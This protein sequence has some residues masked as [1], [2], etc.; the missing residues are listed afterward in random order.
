M[1][2]LYFLILLSL[3]ACGVKQTSLD[4]GKTTVADLVAIKGE[5]EAEEKIPVKEGK[6]LIYPDDEKYQVKGEVVTGGFK[7]PK[8]NEKTLIYW[9]HKLKDCE[10]KLRKVQSKQDGHTMPEYELACE[11]S[12][13][14][15]IYTE[16]SEFV[17]RVIE[18]EKK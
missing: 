2:S 9:K 11:E 10:T 3:A 15:V 12:G 13:L 14:S 18:Y 7:K 1:R 16:G 4:Y 8:G 6:V 17:S 5:P